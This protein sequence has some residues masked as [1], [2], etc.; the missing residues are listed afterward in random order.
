M[1]LLEK[2]AWCWIELFICG[3]EKWFEVMG[4]FENDLNVKCW[5]NRDSGNGLKWFNLRKM[6]RRWIDRLLFLVHFENG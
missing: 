2:G 6:A 3:Y 5:R 1:D 4:G